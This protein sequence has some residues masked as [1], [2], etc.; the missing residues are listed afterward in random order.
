MIK[1]IK[2]YYQYKLFIIKLNDIHISLI[3]LIY[4]YY[5]N[6]RQQYDGFLGLI[7]SYEHIELILN[8]IWIEY[9]L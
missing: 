7:Y 6:E 4:D 2:I 5:K 9:F 8:S 1:I 3:K